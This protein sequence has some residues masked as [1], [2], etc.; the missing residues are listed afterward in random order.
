ML[1]DSPGPWGLPDWWVGL[2][3]ELFDDVFICTPGAIPHALATVSPLL[4]HG[5]VLGFVHAALV[6]ARNPRVVVLQGTLPGPEVLVPLA[7]DPADADVILPGPL[8]G[9]QEPP[10]LPA[11]FNRRC[12]RPLERAL[13]KGEEGLP[14]GLRVRRLE[15]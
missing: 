6:V 11:R 14:A 4:P 3:G 1:R 9:E 12:L 5:A 8:P 15:G 13:R 7:Q 2:A 10:L